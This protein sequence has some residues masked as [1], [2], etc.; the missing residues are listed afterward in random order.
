MIAGSL[1]IKLL[2]WSIILSCNTYY[3]LVDLVLLIWN[4]KKINFKQV[5][6]QRLRHISESSWQHWPNT[7]CICYNSRW[8]DQPVFGAQNIGQNGNVFIVTWGGGSYM[9]PSISLSSLSLLLDILFIFLFFFL[10]YILPSYLYRNTKYYEYLYSKYIWNCW[11]FSYYPD[12]HMN[13]IFGS[14]NLVSKLLTTLTV[15]K[16]RHMKGGGENDVNYITFLNC[17]I[18]S[19][20]LR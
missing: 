18:I 12:I 8:L 16:Y 10:L 14:E 19:L 7:C 2:F 3:H 6:F 20:W 1:N 11:L 17:I 5:W 4:N 13:K 9:G 15:T